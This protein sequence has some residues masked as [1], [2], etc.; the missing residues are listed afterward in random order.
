MLTPAPDTATAGGFSTGSHAGQGA[1][2][3]QRGRVEP[4]VKEEM[5]AAD[6]GGAAVEKKSHDCGRGRGGR[7][8]PSVKEEMTAADNGAAAVEKK[9]HDCGRGRGGKKRGSR[10]RGRDQK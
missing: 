1:N 6:N 7:V 5:T 2:R 9:S 4:S 10:G 8:E 3:L